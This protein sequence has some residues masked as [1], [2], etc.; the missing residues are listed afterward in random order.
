MLYRL[1]RSVKRPDSS[2][3]QSVQRIPADVLPRAANLKLF[4]PLGDGEFQRITISPKAKAVRFSLGTRD[5][6]VAKSRQGRAAAHL[7]EVWRGSADR[8]LSLTN[9]Q[10]HCAGRG[11]IPGM[12]L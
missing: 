7:E 8:P 9:K 2:Q 6:S 12:G 5:I 11:A 10:A 4:I 1:V 3:L